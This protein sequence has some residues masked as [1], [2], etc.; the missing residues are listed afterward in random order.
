MKAMILNDA[1]SMTRDGLGR[2]GSLAKDEIPN[3]C[4]NC[5]SQHNPSI[6][7]HE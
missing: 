2:G 7:R 3:E 1:R 6:V 5:D 4:S